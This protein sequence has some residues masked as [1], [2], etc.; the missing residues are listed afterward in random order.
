MPVH[1]DSLIPTM[2]A[3]AYKSATSSES[4]LM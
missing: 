1:H 4:P 3:A 2:S